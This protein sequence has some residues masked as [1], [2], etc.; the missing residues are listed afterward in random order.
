MSDVRF[1]PVDRATWEAQVRAELKGR[2]FDRT[3]ARVLREG[4]RLQPLYDEAPATATGLGE[5][6]WSRATR[7]PESGIEGIGSDAPHTAVCS[8]WT[9]HDLAAR[10]AEWVPEAR[11]IRLDLRA[12][13]TWEAASTALRSIPS[14]VGLIGLGD[15]RPLLEAA[16]PL[17]LGLDPLGDAAAGW[18]RGSVEAAFDEATEALIACEARPEARALSVSAE[19][20]AAGGAS[21][22]QQLAWLLAALTETLRACEDRGVDVARASRQV[23][24]R[25]TVGRNVFVGI[26]SLRALRLLWSKVLMAWGT[27]PPAPEVHVSL[28]P[29][30]LTRLDPWVN[31]LRGSH[32]AFAALAG[33]ADVL[34]VPPFDSAL[35]EPEELGRRVAR[36]TPLIL[37]EEGHLGRV[38]DPAGGSYFIEHLTDT[39]AREAWARFQ[40]VEAGG[41]LLAAMRRDGPQHE[42]FADARKR[43]NSVGHRRVPVTGVSEFAL[44]DEPVL[45][46]PPV[47]DAP[48]G[49]ITPVP[50]RP[51]SAA[52]EALRAR[53]AVLG[54]P[55]VLLAAVGP[56]AEWSARAS[57][58]RNVFEA[59]GF[60]VVEG[61]GTGDLD[62]V[63]SS[64]ALAPSADAACLV[65]SDRRYATHATD[66]LRVLAAAGPAF[67]AGRP[68]DE[69]QAWTEAGAT[70][71]VHVGCDVLGILTRLVDSLEAR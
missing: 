38:A 59:A 50:L 11:W 6:P 53:V 43:A 5:A 15:G 48:G 17:R 47:P 2:P 30:V 21:T 8:T 32:G 34:E 61:E 45:Q 4:I 56:R 3:L 14:D 24:L 1:P 13:L 49:D 46:R 42:L 36:N 35:G 23:V 40:G 37:T 18:A 27:A 64:A 10:A 63:A 65:G 58:T 69:R 62:P 9:A 39:L 26:A 70:A 57:W 71:F 16:R 68:G 25:P 67:L 54:R 52:F 22:T 31:L 60:A 51:D 19:P 20:W 29:S 12:G 44:P 7:V 33:G 41:G 55:T 28:N 66:A